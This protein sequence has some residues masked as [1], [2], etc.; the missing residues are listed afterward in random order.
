MESECNKVMSNK[1]N[2][3]KSILKMKQTF[4]ILIELKTPL[5]TIKKT[6]GKSRLSYKMKKEETHKTTTLA[7]FY[8][9][10]IARK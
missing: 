9:V 5:T 4:K 2:M 8:W 1:I 10:L 3:Q 7:K 6:H